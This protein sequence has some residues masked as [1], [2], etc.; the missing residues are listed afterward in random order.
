MALVGPK[1]LRKSVSLLDTDRSD[2]LYRIRIKTPELREKTSP[3]VIRWISCENELGQLICSE[4]HNI[5]RKAYDFFLF[6]GL[7]LVKVYFVA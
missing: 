6:Q 3:A 7:D 4:E 1:G 5:T 2:A